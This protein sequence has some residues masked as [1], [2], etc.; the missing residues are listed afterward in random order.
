MKINFDFWM[1]KFNTDIA[2]IKSQTRL[3]EYTTW[4]IDNEV[5]GEFVDFYFQHCHEWR[6]K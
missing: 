3:I 5:N 1:K 6:E 2:V 4:C